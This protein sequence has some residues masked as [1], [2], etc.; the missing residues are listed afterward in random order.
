M[1]K[2]LLVMLKDEYDVVVVGG[3]PGGSATAET[4]AKKGLRVALLE[5]RQEIGSPKRCG[6][7]L[8]GAG[9]GLFKEIPKRCI[10]Q[11]INGAIIYAPNGKNV[12][13]EGENLN[14]FIVERKYFDKWLAFNASRAGAY[15]QAK[16]EVTDVIK[17]NGFVTGVKANHEGDKY[18]IKA[19]VVVASDGVESTIAR[20]AGLNTTNQ[21]INIDAGYQYEMSNL[22]LKDPHKIELW[23]NNKMSPRGYVWV[24]PKGE[25]VA[26]VGIGVAMCEKSARYYLDKFIEK[27][28]H[29][30]KNSSIIEVNSGGIPVGGFLKNMVMNGFMV[31]GDAAHQVNPIHGGGIKEATIAGRIAGDIISKGM[32]KNDVSEK[33]LSEY[34]KIWWKERGKALVRV[35]KLR[36]VFEKLTDE[37]LN[38]LQK[39]LTGDDLFEFSRGGRLGKLARIL[40]KKPSLLKLARHL[41]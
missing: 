14:G 27:N 26:N 17:N 19:K 12:I 16:T 35:Q 22:K 38:M 18:E 34:N 4:L 11:T 21:L 23:F 32:Q 15:I 37:D 41:L 1:E 40:M 31:V 6:E 20:K 25:D 39:T 7:G 30:F 33:V 29:I 13:V 28:S 10:T 24:F 2:G 8:T 36:E 5:K 9:L 3:G